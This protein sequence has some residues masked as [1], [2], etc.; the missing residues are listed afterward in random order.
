MGCSQS[1]ESCNRRTIV[2]EIGSNLRCEF[3]NQLYMPCEA[4]STFSTDDAE[5]DK[6]ERIK[7]R[8]CE[9]AD[10]M[11]HGLVNMECLVPLHRV[12]FSDP[13]IWSAQALAEPKS[14]LLECPS[15]RRYGVLNP[16]GKALRKHTTQLPFWI[17]HSCWKAQTSD[18]Y[19]QRG[20]NGCE[21]GIG[22]PCYVCSKCFAD[23][24]TDDSDCDQQ[25]FIAKKLTNALELIS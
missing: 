11:R 8:V 4:L 17:C 18:V 19:F 20:D 12:D 15:T 7:I 14:S 16:C 10:A 22:D 24:A 13:R 23:S 6:D 3:F 9:S 5:S 25:Q 1:N 2:I 21:N